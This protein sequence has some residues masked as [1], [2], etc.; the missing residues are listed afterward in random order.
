MADATVRGFLMVAA[1]VG[2]SVAGLAH[3][4][5]TSVTVPGIADIW[6]AGQPNGTVLNGGFPGSDVAPTNSPVLA[7]TGLSLT[8]GSTLTIA[9]TG[10]T[11]YNGCASLNP[12]GGA[13]CGG[14]SFPAALGVSGYNGPINAL[15]GVFLDASTPAGAAPPALD[16]STPGSLA[17]PT[18]A[19]QLRQVF[20]IGDGRTG[21]GSGT[22]QQFVV[23]AGATRLFLASS[24]GIG[25]NY[26]NFGSFA[27][28]VTDSVVAAAVAADIPVDAPWALSI[29]M[30]LLLAAGAYALRRR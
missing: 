12:D 21:T 30:L 23:P 22:A 6:L 24:D 14:G 10:A 26:N 15:I 25:A 16:F 4:A 5:S 20:F 29:T 2:S 27:V 13:P 19:P 3:G 28:V 17:Q 8:A 18:V 9:A 7:S 11:D 1:L